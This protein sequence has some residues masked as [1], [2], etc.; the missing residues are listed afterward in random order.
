MG[1]ILIKQL[2]LLS[3][4]YCYIVHNN[5]SAIVI[6]PS[7]GEAVEKYLLS[8]NVT[9]RAILNT[10]SH[11]DHTGGNSYLSKKFASSVCDFGDYEELDF[12]FCKVKVLRTPGHTADSVVFF[13]D[14]EKA[15][16]T[17]DTLFAAGCGR[18][19]TSSCRVMWESLK[20]IKDMLDDVAVYPGHNYTRENLRFAYSI[21]PENDKIKVYMDD[22][23][24]IDS[25]VSLIAVEKEI[26]IFLNADN[27]ELQVK[28]FGKFADS[29][30]V[31]CY[32]REKKDYF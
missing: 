15:L 13:I 25:G 22:D 2:R 26:N 4:N 31:F 30:G 20:K 17:G 8:N 23:G 16:F 3:D 32:L 21:W 12:G 28:L 29:A 24:F 18:V 27:P 6:D 9:L 19:F 14:E 7:E 10:H 1:D 11:Y 5:E